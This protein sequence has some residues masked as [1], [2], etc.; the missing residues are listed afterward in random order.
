MPP[1]LLVTGT[2]DA[3]LS[4]TAIYD[5]ALVKSGVDAQLLVYEAMP[6]AFWYHFE[7]PETRECLELMAKFFND[8][9][10]KATR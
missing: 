2:R 6:H 5:L 8:H 3:L 10:G 9:V 7:F 4:G 1:T